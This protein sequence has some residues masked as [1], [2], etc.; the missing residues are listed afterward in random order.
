MQHISLTKCQCKAPAKR[1]Q[2]CWVQHV[3]C[4]FPICWDLIRHVLT[5]WVLLAQIWKLSNSSFNICGCCMM[6]WSFGQVCATMLRLG[7]RTSSIFNSQ[8]VATCCNRVA[9]RTQHVPLND[10]TICCVQMLRSCG[11]SLQLLGQEC[12]VMLRWGVVIVWPGLKLSSS[13]L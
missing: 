5:C 9:K 12:W 13:S 1:S 2:H 3:A 8:H 6:L 11:R 10:V 4:V 7:M